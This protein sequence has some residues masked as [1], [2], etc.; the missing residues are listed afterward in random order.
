M[1]ATY[2]FILE[3]GA[4]VNINYVRQ[5]GKQFLQSIIWLL[6]WCDS[7]PSCRWNADLG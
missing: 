2:V 7:A 1:G 4:V 6:S 3:N 5:I